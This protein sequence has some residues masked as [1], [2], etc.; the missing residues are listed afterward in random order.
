MKEQG[1]VEGAIDL[2]KKRLMDKKK[3]IFVVV[4]NSGCGM[5]YLSVQLSERLEKEMS[6]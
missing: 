1:V 5:S 2:L 3:V 6:E 4:G